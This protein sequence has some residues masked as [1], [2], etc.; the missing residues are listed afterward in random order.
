MDTYNKYI[1]RTVEYK[2]NEQVRLKC[3]MCAA[4]AHLLISKVEGWLMI[5]E[6][7][8]QSEKITSLLDYSV[9]QLMEN[10]HVTIEVGNKY[11]R[12]PAVQAGFG[13]ANKTAS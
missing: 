13:I 9:E 11:R 2:E 8:P 6:N 5:M 10:Q 1:R 4:L 12:G 7:V 3:R